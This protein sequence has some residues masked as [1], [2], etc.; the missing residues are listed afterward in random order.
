[1]GHG[2]LDMDM[3]MGHGTWDMGRGTWDMGHGK[4]VLNQSVSTPAAAPLAGHSAKHVAG[5]RGGV[6]CH[7]PYYVARMAVQGRVW[8]RLHMQHAHVHAHDMC[9]CMCMSARKSGTARPPSFAS[10][11]LLML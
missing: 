4:T 9:M 2:T 6:A 10:C 8:L 1:M 5:S 3:D 7:S 11:L